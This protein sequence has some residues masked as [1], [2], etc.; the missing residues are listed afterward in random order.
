MVFFLLIADALVAILGNAPCLIG[1]NQSFPFAAP[2]RD[3]DSQSI[4]RQLAV[5]LIHFLVGWLAFD[6]GED[7]EPETGLGAFLVGCYDRRS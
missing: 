1:T 4:S 3:L 2:K 5:Y 6:D 7:L